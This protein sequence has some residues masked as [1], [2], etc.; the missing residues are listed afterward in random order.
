MSNVA[1]RHPETLTSKLALRAGSHS[2]TAEYILR[3]KLRENPK[4]CGCNLEPREMMNLNLKE[5]MR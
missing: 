1:I 4:T 5:M 2:F 3:Q